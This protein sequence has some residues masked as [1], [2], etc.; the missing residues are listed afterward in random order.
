MFYFGLIFHNEVKRTT[1][2]LINELLILKLEG[3]VGYCLA[4]L[5]HAWIYNDNTIKRIEERLKLQ[6]KQDHFIGDVYKSIPGVGSISAR[7]LAN[8]LGAKT[9]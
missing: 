2:K 5:C 3:D 4:E 6:A 9:P 7:I 1:R 8:E